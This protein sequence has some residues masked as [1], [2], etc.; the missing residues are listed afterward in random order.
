MNIGE[1]AKNSGVNSKMIR[2][3]ESIKLIPK[4]QRNSSGYRVYGDKDV[5]TL[6]FVRR[7]R[8]LGFPL[9]EIKL[10]LGLW[11]NKKRTSSKVKE[12]AQKHIDELQNKIDDLQSMRDSL[13]HLVKNCHG[14]DRP[15]CPIIESLSK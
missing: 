10:L 2:H 15:D 7:A 14:D 1:L 8:S 3:Y 13:D 11:K 5:H 4:A 6:S 9:E 12:L